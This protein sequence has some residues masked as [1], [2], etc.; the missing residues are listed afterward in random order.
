MS[1]LC[2]L[3]LTVPTVFRPSMACWLAA[4]NY[5]LEEGTVEMDGSS[6]AVRFRI[7]MPI[8]KEHPSA[9]SMVKYLVGCGRYNSSLLR[10]AAAGFQGTWL[11]A[12]LGGE[13]PTLVQVNLSV[14][15]IAGMNGQ[16][17]GP[18]HA[19]EDELAATPNR[20]P[21]APDY[22]DGGSCTS[23]EDQQSP[24]RQCADESTTAAADTALPMLAQFGGVHGAPT[25]F[26]SPVPALM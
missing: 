26:N 21:L 12:A 19:A 4:V 25:P 8:I 24:S 6:G 22:H 14:Q 2:A 11:A 7:A 10:R 17:V 18:S 3:D 23:R 20:T 16:L 5:R 13:P 15:S 9:C 1:V